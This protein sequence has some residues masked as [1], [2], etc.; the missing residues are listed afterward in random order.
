VSARP[1]LQALIEE[2]FERRG[3]LTPQNLPRPLDAALE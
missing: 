1:Q 2:A 3:A